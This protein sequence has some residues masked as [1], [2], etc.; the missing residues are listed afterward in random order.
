VL[1]HASP[2]GFAASLGEL[3]HELVELIQCE[4]G[5]LDLHG[6]TL[7]AGGEA[8]HRLF[9]IDHA[10]RG[11]VGE[12]AVDVSKFV[13][14]VHHVLIRTDVEKNRRAASSLCEDQRSARIADLLEHRGSVGAKVRDGLNVRLEIK[15][16]LRHE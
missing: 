14:F 7:Q 13:E 11:D 5:P 2:N 3:V 16:N 9:V 12:S 15:G 10:A 6:S 8:N 4:F 1:D